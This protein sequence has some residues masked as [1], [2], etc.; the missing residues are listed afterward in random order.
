M[1]PTP[2]DIEFLFEIGALRNITRAWSQTLGMDSA[3]IS[4]HTFRVVWLALLFARMEGVKNEEKI[5]K[6]ALVHDIAESRTGDAN[7][8]Q[9]VYTTRD[10]DRALRDMLEGTHIADFYSEILTAYDKRESIEARI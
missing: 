2:R 1:K 4:E 8:T 5:M 9:A 7:Y 10:E 6:M 3:S